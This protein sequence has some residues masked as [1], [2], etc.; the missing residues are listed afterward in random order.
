MSRLKAVFA[1]VGCLALLT[2]PASPARGQG[3]VAFAPVI[4]TIP[5]GATLTVTPVVTADRRYVRMSLVPQFIA[6]IQ[7]DTISVPAA[8]A[9]FG[10]G[11]GGLGGGNGG[12]GQGFR[13]VGFGRGG[14]TDG[15]GNPATATPY[16]GMV[17]RGTGS[18]MG[19]PYGRPARMTRQQF[20]DAT[21]GPM[22]A[23]SR[24][25]RRRGK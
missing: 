1:A 15:Y 22:A 5:D 16:D 25:A 4:G 9:G 10:N 11:L 18:G 23:P 13:N 24:P 6:F 2:L 19:S 17:S 21:M 7:F 20:L 14:V 8:V 3:A 12:G